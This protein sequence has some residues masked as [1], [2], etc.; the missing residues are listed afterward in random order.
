MSCVLLGES[1]SNETFCPTHEPLV[2]SG[3]VKD[4]G[5]RA[6]DREARRQDLFI[7]IKHAIAP[8]YL[9][10]GGVLHRLSW[11]AA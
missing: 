3:K 6:Q 11:R 7:G 4:A 1:D 10:R 2:K 8:S 9:T 5:N